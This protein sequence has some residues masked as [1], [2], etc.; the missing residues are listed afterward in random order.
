MAFTLLPREAKVACEGFATAIPTLCCSTSAS[1]ASAP[2]T[3]ILQSF[4]EASESF[5]SSSS[6]SSPCEEAWTLAGPKEQLRSHQGS[7]SIPPITNPSLGWAQGPGT[8]GTP[9]RHSK[10]CTIGGH[11]SSLRALP[12]HIGTFLGPT[13]H[14]ANDQIRS[15]CPCV[16]VPLCLAPDNTKI[17][18]QVLAR[19]GILSSCM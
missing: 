10:G 4:T 13:M 5:S 8:T 14:S 19:C 15:L 2:E 17:A 1:D 7:L 12:Y 18:K 9:T 6:S 3:P 16:I 11:Y